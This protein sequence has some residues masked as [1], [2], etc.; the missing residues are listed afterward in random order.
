M[1]F[2]SWVTIITLVLLA[3]VI[4]FGRHEITHA[5][6]LLGGVNIWILVLIIPV[7]L[8]SYYA[9]GGMIFAYLRAKGNLKNTTHWQMTRMAL[10]LNFVNHILPSGGA[11][12][13]SYLGWVLGRHGVSPGRATMAQIVRFLMGFSAFIV[14][15]FVAVIGLTLDH[16]VNHV[17]III[18]SVLTTAAILLLI[19]SVFVIGSKKRLDGFSGWL[20]RTANKAVSFF[21]MGRKK[22]VLD[23]AAIQPFFYE[24]HEDFVQIKADKRIL[25]KPFLWGLVMNACDV[26]LLAIAFMSLGFFVNPATLYVAFGVS[27]IASVFSVTPGG[28]GVYETI[29]ITFLASAGIPADIAIAGTLLARV[30]LLLGTIVFGY[31]FYQLTIVKYG[32]NPIQR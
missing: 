21:T 7:Q 1:S 26:A 20:T 24:L 27:S 30:S 5:F 15:L 12:G 19:L 6:H 29:M 8:L 32:K 31:F 14:L 13:F 11:A 25:I 4:Y 23:Q 3:L 2:R 18:S 28:A 10:E 22:K 17:I 16:H 9:V